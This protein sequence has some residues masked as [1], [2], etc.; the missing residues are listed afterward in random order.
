MV[1][2][3]QIELMTKVTGKSLAKANLVG[4]NDRKLFPTDKLSTNVR[5][6]SA[7]R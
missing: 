5:K 1:I 3:V 6:P 2:V 7:R 4:Y